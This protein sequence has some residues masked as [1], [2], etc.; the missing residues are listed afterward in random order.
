MYIIIFLLSFFQHEM[1]MNGFA[2]AE[3]KQVFYKTNAYRKSKGLDTLQWDNAL[4]LSG[5][6]HATNMDRYN[7]F[8]HECKQN[9]QFQ[10]PGNRIKYFN[11]NYSYMSENIAFYE[12]SKEAM[13]SEEVAEMFFKMWEKSPNHR[14]NML[15]KDA[16][17]LGVA[18]YTVYKGKKIVYYGVQ[19]FGKR[20]VDK[21]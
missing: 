8:G 12:T 9:K 21:K 13:T 2:I 7:F 4:F 6:T 14:K 20:L 16:N 18:I 17:D 3:N 5:Y 10:K 11:Y 19:N 15:S 1:S